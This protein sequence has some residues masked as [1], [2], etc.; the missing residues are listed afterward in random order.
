MFKNS[1]NPSLFD[2][3]IIKLMEPKIK[4][5]LNRVSARDFEDVEQDLKLKILESINNVRIDETPG[6]WEFKRKVESH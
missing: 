2:E 3:H 1:P 5:V 4:K 6:F